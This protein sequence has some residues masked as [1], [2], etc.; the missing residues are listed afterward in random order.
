M[1]SMQAQAHAFALAAARTRRAARGSVLLAALAQECAAA[2]VA[3]RMTGAE[4]TAEA[5]PELFGLHRA[6]VLA[7]AAA[8][9]QSSAIR[10]DHAGLALSVFATLGETGA[11]ESFEVRS[12]AS[13]ALLMRATMAGPVL[14]LPAAKVAAP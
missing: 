13:G 1:A 3:K 14:A 8:R 6:A 7:I 4:P 5:C 9:G 12:A 2:A 10:L 11:V